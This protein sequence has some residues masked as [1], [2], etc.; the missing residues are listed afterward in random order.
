VHA[1]I[2][3]LRTDR[4]QLAGEPAFGMLGG[5]DAG[6]GEGTASSASLLPANPLR[7]L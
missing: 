6:E 3:D 2:G 4:D 1:V 5:Q 7:P